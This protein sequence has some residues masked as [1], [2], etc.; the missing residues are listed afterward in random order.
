MAAHMSKLLPLIRST[1]A[2]PGYVCFG[3]ADAALEA[4]ELGAEQS[5]ASDWPGC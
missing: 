3:D 2:R 4:T 1:G 5:A